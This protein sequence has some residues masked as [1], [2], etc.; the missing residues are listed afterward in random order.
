M[1]RRAH[2][3]TIRHYA[4]G[5]PLGFVIIYENGQAMYSCMMIEL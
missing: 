2:T 1:N 4:D 3:G 5:A